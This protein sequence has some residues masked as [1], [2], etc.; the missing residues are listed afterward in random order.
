MTA[1]PTTVNR[2]VGLAL[3]GA[4]VLA[5]S[6]DPDPRRAEGP[7]TTTRPAIE[8]ACADRT[9]HVVVVGID[10]L[11]ADSLAPA[12]APALDRLFAEGTSTLAGYAG[13]E[14]GTPTEQP[15]VSGPGWATI[16]TGTW[17]DRHGVTDNEFTTWRPAEPHFFERLNEIDPET[18]LTSIV[19]WIPVVV[20]VDGSADRGETGLAAQVEELAVDEVTNH[21]PTVMFLHFDDVDHAGHES[22]Y[23]PDRPDYLAAIASVDGHVDAILDA[24]AAR[25]TRDDECW[26]TIVVTDHGGTGTGHGGQTPEE[27]TIPFAVSGDGIPAVNVTDGPGHDVVPSTVFAYLGLPADASWRWPAPFAIDAVP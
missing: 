3:A 19:Q 24:I 25:P 13:G 23:G 11:R 22:G 18:R 5:C 2:F 9:R 21:S 27:R 1:T 7:T 10:G 6:D 17:S 20:L 8:E 12:E 14:L 16:L 26:A 15:T 4:L